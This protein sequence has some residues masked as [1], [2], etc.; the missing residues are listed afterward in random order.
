MFNP[1]AANGFMSLREASSFHCAPCESETTPHFCWLGRISAQHGHPPG[2]TSLAWSTEAHDAPLSGVVVGS[3]S[4]NTKVLSFWS[5]SK[6]RQSKFKVQLWRSW[7]NS[8]SQARAWDPDVSAIQH[9]R[10][11]P[12][13]L[14]FWKLTVAWCGCSHWASPLN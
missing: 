2:G 11:F 7:S 12:L 6:R 9:V 1:G 5:D 14:C 10:G 3:A 13:A 4:P 8:T